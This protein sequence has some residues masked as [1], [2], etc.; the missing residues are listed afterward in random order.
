MKNLV[1]LFVLV[2]VLLSSCVGTGILPRMTEIS[3]FEVVQ[4]I[5]ID[6]KD[7]MIAVT[8]VAD[9]SGPAGGEGASAQKTS[10]IVSFTGRTVVEAI[11]QM[12]IYSDKRQHLGYVDFLLIG[13]EAARDGITKYIDFFTRDYESRYSANVFIIRGGAARDFLLDTAS[14]DRSINDAL[15]NIDESI[16]ELSVSRLYRL[17]D[18]VGELGLPYRAAIIPA[19]RCKDF[20]SAEMIGGEMPKKAFEPDGFAFLKDFKLV[21][22][23]DR[24]LSPAYNCLIEKAHSTPVTVAD[25]SGSLVALELH[26]DR[27]AFSPVWDGDTL[28]GV[29]YDFLMFA[30]LTEQLGLDDIY[31]E[32]ALSEIEKNASLE[33][34]TA[35]EAVIA[36]SQKLGQDGFSLGE[37]IRQKSPSKWKKLEMEKKWGDV[38]PSLKVEVT[39]ETQVRRTYDLREPTGLYRSETIEGGKK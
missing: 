24:E 31:T 21:G 27:L 4:V 35:I 37:R 12:D 30:S 9:R 36:Q 14:E 2:P 16:E 13:E 17:I 22:Y 32:A 10:E 20:G 33:V 5:G 7:D 38:F 3:D 28:K 39:V 34:K 8:L 15:D 29:K 11:S 6:K 26:P 19:L 18:L 23:Y 1:S 25:P